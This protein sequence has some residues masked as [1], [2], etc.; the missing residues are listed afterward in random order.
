MTS[1]YISSTCGDLKEHRMMVAETLRRCGYDGQNDQVLRF[2]QPLLEGDSFTTEVLTLALAMFYA[3]DEELL[4]G[5]RM[6]YKR[7]RANVSLSVDP[8]F[9]YVPTREFGLARQTRPIE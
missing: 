2:V 3:A 5:W 1:I 7:H 4:S 6:L 8:F 9:V